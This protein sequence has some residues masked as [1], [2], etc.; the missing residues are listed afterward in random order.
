MALRISGVGRV[1]VSERR[2]IGVMLEKVITTRPRGVRL[3]CTRRLAVTIQNGVMMQFFHWYSPGDGTL[4]N[5][6]ASRAQ[7]LAAAGF[8]GV[9]LPPAYKGT[10]GV[11]DVGY[12]V[13]DMY[14]LGEFDQKGSCRTRY[15]TKKQYLSAVKALHQAGLQVY[16]DTVLNHR[17]GGDATE[18][19]R[20][21]PFS[22]DDRLRP[23]GEAREVEAYT[24][25]RFPGRKGKHSKF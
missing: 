12:G 16:A 24:D 2:S 11:S 23:K 4:W 1:T 21:T 10:S 22:Q 25:F 14:D 9:W 3:R 17:M 6:A 15:G 8:T 7:E 19:V 5:E 13:Y 18:V 20:A